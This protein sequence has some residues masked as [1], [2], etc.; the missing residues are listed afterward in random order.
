MP[1]VAN[2]RYE[3]DAV[4][5]GRLEAARLHR[6]SV[7]EMQRNRWTP[8]LRRGAVMIVAAIGLPVTASLA[9]ACSESA[10]VSSLN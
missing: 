4:P 10:N 3:G 1:T 9:T 7:V 6:G 8:A 2:L 5:E